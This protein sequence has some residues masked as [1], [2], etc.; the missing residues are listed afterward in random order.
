MQQLISYLIFCLLFLCCPTIHA[1]VVDTGNE[2]TEE[3]EEAEDDTDAP[4]GEEDDEVAEDGYA[5]PSQQVLSLKE[6]IDS[7]L[8]AQY[9]QTVR[10]RIYVRSRS[11]RRRRVYR[12]YHIS[13]TPTAGCM[14]YD[15]TTD[16]IIYQFHPQR[17]LI[18]ASTQKLF[19]A[20]AMLT[21]YGTEHI[22]ETTRT[23]VSIEDSLNGTRD[24]II[25]EE[26]PLKPEMR[27][28][29]KSSDNAKAEKML[30]RLIGSEEEEEFHAEGAIDD[31]Q[32]DEWTYEGC[33]DVVRN[34]V[35]LI[36]R[37]YHPEENNPAD[38]SNYY[39]IADGSGLSHANQTTAESQV[40]L[41]RFAY[42]DPDIFP[43]L[44]DCLPIA[45][46]DG[47]LGSR[48]Q[49]TAAYN[50]VHA[51]TGTVSRVSTLSGYVKD[52]RGHDLAFSILI[53]DCDSSTYA[54]A[55]QNKICELLAEMK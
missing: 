53:N 20:M 26:I 9:S 8:T 23:T 37:I 38:L 22:Y 5:L 4:D 2:D 16:S 15:L 49:G 30:R 47:T 43:Y 50:N 7:L 48:M 46:I 36:R 44:Y 10:R 24:S 25:E 28:M 35:T 14:V 55:L 17:M 42:H 1:Q 11:R 13:G 31:S 41:L 32:K 52:T 3:I 29:L 21:T 19:T 12:T 51:K 33:K 40:D 45:G 54:R 34:M 6:Y 18:P 27:K 39:N